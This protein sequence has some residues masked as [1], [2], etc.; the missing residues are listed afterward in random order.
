MSDHA[1]SGR[2][3]PL[4]GWVTVVTGAG[5]GIGAAI[6]AV[7]SRQGARVAAFDLSFPA[8]CHDA[9][10]ELVCDVTDEA[11]VASAVT[12]V[13]DRLG[14]VQALVN[15]AGRNSYADPIR[16][17][18]QEWDSVFAVDLKGAWL[19]AKHVLP[20]MIG[21]GGGAI[22]NVASIHAELTQSGMFPYAAA[23]SGLV[24]LT[25]SLALDMARHGIRVNAVS[26]G[27]VRTELLEDYLARSDEP[28]LLEEILAKQPLGRLA[29][30]EEIA[31]VVCFLLSPAASFVTG[32]VWPVDGGLGAR[33]A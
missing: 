4:S 19:V 32:S 11:S 26:P 13:E 31:Q 3:G 33:F 2:P 17:T 27:Y 28:G 29:Q 30:P 18:E 20:Q 25:R 23:K 5:R 12:L 21:A 6:A 8:T 9:G 7:A 15:N 14:P 24:G 22:V 16:M 10:L 1:M